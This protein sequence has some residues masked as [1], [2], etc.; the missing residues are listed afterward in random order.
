MVYITVEAWILSKCKTKK[1]VGGVWFKQRK[2]L[3]FCRAGKGNFSCLKIILK[4]IV[5]ATRKKYQTE[6]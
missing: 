3:T 5:Q 4:F 2:G 6:A 1:S